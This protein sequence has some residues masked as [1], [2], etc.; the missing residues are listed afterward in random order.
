M[1]CLKKQLENLKEQVSLAPKTTFKIGGPARFFFVAQ[2]KEDVVKAVSAANSCNVPFFV[3]A[4]GSNVVV[5]DEGFPGL[6]IHVQLN[7]YTIEATK[8]K[9]SMKGLTPITEQ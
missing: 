6:V 3:L 2:T 4:G 8:L 7:N 1:D 5:S 9:C